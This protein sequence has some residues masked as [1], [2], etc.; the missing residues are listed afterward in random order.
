LG[1]DFFEIFST[2]W[3]R[4]LLTA[5][6]RG[7]YIFIEREESTPLPIGIALSF[8][9][10]TYNVLA[11]AYANRAWYRRTPA[12][13]LDPIWRVPALVQYIAAT[14]AH[15][16]CLQEVE[17]H[18]LAAL[19]LRLGPAGYGTQYGRKNAGRPDGCAIFY[20]QADFDL[21]HASVLAYADGG[22]AS[23]DSGNVALIARFRGVEGV[24][25]V[26][27]THLTWDPPGTPLASRRGYRQACQLLREREKIADLADAWILT[28]DFN[29]TPDSEIV[30]M[31]ERAGFRYAH[32]DRAG[33]YTCNF[34]AQAKMIDYLFHTSGLSS[35]PQ[36]IIA[37]GDG[38]VLPCA[39]EPSDHVAIAARFESR[40]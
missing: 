12:L 34:N 21:I 8:S 39:E 16:I 3:V 23:A 33:V 31:I 18:V 17:P 38:T 28:G 32:R 1:K 29:V 7:S 14:A 19:R 6:R 4:R 25:G 40:A 35:E 5:K 36:A 11:D 26:V 22:G 13:V 37:I 24:I 15:I 9:V 30:A 10:T 27:N 20:R 2:G